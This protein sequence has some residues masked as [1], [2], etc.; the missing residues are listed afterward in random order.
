M[1]TKEQLRIAFFGTPIFATVILDEMDAGGYTPMLVITQEDK[2][3]GRHLE[4]VPTEVKLWA[5]QHDVDVIT[6]RG[7]VSGDP[8]LS[9]L[10]NSEWDL[11]VVASYGNILPQNILD[12]PKHGVLNVHPSLL[13][14]LRGASPVRT[15][16][17]TDQK[18]AVGVSIMLLDSEMDHG[19]IVAQARIEP[20][21]WPMG[22]L[23]LEELLAHVGGQLL[24]EAIPPYIVGEIIPESQ[25][26]SVA[27]YSKKIE[28][29]MGEVEL[30]GNP[31]ENLRRI[32]ALE[33]WPCAYFFIKKDGKPFRVKIIDA[34]INVD[35]GA[36]EILRV[37]P[38]GK[39]EMDYKDFK[40]S[41]LS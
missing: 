29:H 5:E 30:G 11:F 1:S 41:Y 33:G 23:L 16:I 40:R 28:K 32:K 12:I 13:P 25:D 10:F 9:L 2:A 26:H 35:G 8:S 38:E 31:M 4:V 19:P 15:A 37:I 7:L 39:K 24:V 14:K 18:D 27:T 6:P 34:D 21:V 22:A 20:E 3:R 17:L 36:L